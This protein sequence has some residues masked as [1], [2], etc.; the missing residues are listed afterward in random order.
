MFGVMRQFKPGTESAGKVT[1]MISVILFADSVISAASNL[2]SV[3]DETER[4]TGNLMLFS[5]ELP[6]TRSVFN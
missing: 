4:E 6:F 2:R 1:M 3:F 5:G